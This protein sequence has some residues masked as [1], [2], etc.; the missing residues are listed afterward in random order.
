MIWSDLTMM[1]EIKTA[2]PTKNYPCKIFLLQ[3]WHFVYQEHVLWKI[4][5]KSQIKDD[6]TQNRSFIYL[7]IFKFPIWTL[8]NHSKPVASNAICLYT[9]NLQASRMRP[10]DLWPRGKN[11]C[12]NLW[13]L[14]ASLKENC[15]TSAS[16]CADQKWKFKINILL[17][18]VLKMPLQGFFH[19]PKQDKWTQIFKI[20]DILTV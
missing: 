18:F 9:W 13:P 17:V 4:I 14:A 15:K 8:H 3:N 19:V 20:L 6:L 16:V 5:Y 10:T 2:N 1:S 11:S 7:F 12:L